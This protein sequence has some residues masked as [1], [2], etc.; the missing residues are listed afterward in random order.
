MG[1][2]VAYNVRVQARARLAAGGGIL[3][4]LLAALPACGSRAGQ[5]PAIL[6]LGRESVRRSEFLRHLRTFEARDQGALDPTVRRALLDAFLEQRVLVLEGRARG[7]LGPDATAEDE[8]LAVQ[9]LLLES[10]NGN[11][12]PSQEAVAEFYRAHPEE[13]RVPELVTVRQIVVSSANEARDICRRLQKDPKNFEIL[14]RTLSR[15]PE[16]AQGGLLGPGPFARGELPVEI[17]QAAFAL[18]P[19]AQT[20]IA[21]TPLGH[22]VLRVDAHTPERVRTLDECADHIRSILALRKQDLASRQLVR[23][24][25]ARAKVNYEAAEGPLLS[26]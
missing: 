17:E 7:L 15:S 23:E 6:V 4:V 8:E 24:L 14:A 19:G 26:H 1:R 2:T 13:C 25:L 9:R 16:A 20:A 5:D 11:S 22:H 3:A 18:P 21:V 12:A 10:Q